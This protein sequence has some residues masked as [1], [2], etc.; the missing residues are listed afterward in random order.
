MQ[1]LPFGKRPTQQ[2]IAKLPPLDV[3]AV[4]DLPFE[5][6]WSGLGAQRHARTVAN[7]AHVP[8]HFHALPRRTQP[9]EGALAL[10]PRK[11]LSGRPFDPN[12]ALKNLF[13]HA[14]RRF[15]RIRQAS[16]QNFTSS[17]TFSHFLRQANSR[18]HT[19]HGFDGSSDF[20]RIFG[21]AT[22]FIAKVPKVHLPSAVRHRWFEFRVHAPE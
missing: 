6:H 17:H 16:E 10:V 8:R 22:T 2:H 19:T 9:G 21:I 18:P 3:V 5:P 13:S 20:F 11:H 4:L 12:R 14:S 1:M 15:F 7:P